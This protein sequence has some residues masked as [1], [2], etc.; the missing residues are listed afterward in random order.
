M[1]TVCEDHLDQAI[2][3]FIVANETSPDLYLLD[4]A[5]FTGWTAP[6]HCDY[7]LNRPVYLIV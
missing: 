6:S 7:C 4:N 3:E 5:S 2:E 1:Y